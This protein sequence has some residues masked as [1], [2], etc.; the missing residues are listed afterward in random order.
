MRFVSVSSILSSLSRRGSCLCI[1]ISG[2]SLLI[3]LWLLFQWLSSLSLGGITSWFCGSCPICSTCPACSPQLVV[4]PKC[5]CHA[6]LRNCE[7]NCIPFPAF[8]SYHESWSSQLLT[9]Q[10]NG[11]DSEMSAL[12]FKRQLLFIILGLLIIVTFLLLVLCFL[13]LFGPSCRQRYRLRQQRLQLARRQYV[14]RKHN[15]VAA[16]SVSLDTDASLVSTI[17][18]SSLAVGLPS[19][20]IISCLDSSE[21]VKLR[22]NPPLAASFNVT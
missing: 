3:I 11:H 7:C 6:D 17:S 13:L 12:S 21:A 8:Q 19:R 14:M 9:E 18:P 2:V 15:L 16:P 5:E 20:S 22:R 10:R 4:S 1:M